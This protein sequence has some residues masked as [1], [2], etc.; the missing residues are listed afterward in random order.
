MYLMASVYFG[1]KYLQTYDRFVGMTWS[2]VKREA[3]DRSQ[4]RTS[5]E[6]LGPI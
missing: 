2:Q 3:E 5:V 6:A 4:W 1:L